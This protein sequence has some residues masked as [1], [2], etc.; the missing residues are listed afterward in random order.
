MFR[1]GEFSTIARVSAVL[2]R[3]YD[4]I[5]LFKPCHIDSENGYRYYSIDQLPQLNRILALKDLGFS[6][7]EIGRLLADNVSA[8]EIQGMLMLR[9]SQIEQA[10]DEETK[11]LR[12]IKG[13][14]K[15]IQQ[16]G[17]L[18][19]HD[20]V[21]KDIPAQYFLSIR[22]CAYSMTV[23]GR[24]YYAILDALTAHPVDGLSYPMAMFHD[25]VFTHEDIDWELG[26]LVRN[27]NVG[28]VPMQ[29][30]RQ[31]VVR[32]LEAVGK[33]ATAVHAGPWA[34]M[35]LGYA[36]IGSWIESNNYRIAGPSREVYLNL[37]PPDN[38]D[39]FLVEIQIPVER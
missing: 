27:T 9:Q 38:D 34:E 28:P 35:H 14:L 16:A 4:E 36:A 23:M 32:G 17:V 18:T 11:R 8:E 20:V 15:Q 26:F 30:G 33:M 10:L 3:H 13:R 19:R 22:E 12:R 31:M 24:L 5:D 2:L 1:I 6:L 37:V 39:S 25:P 21:L 7:A 29:D